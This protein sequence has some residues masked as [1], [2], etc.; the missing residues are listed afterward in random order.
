MAQ[1]LVVAGLRLTGREGDRITDVSFTAPRGS[2]TGLVGPNGGGKSTILKILAGICRPVAG[3]AVFDGNDL[4]V[5]RPPERA[6]SVALLEQDFADDVPM[7]VWDVVDIG[8]TPFRDTWTGDPAGDRIVEESLHRVGC[9]HL[10]Q[11][12]FYDLSGGERQRVRL[13]RC[14]AQQPKLLLLDEPNNHLDIKGQFEMIDILR[15]LVRDGLAVVAVLHDLN[16]A[17]SY[18][19]RLTVIADGHS[20]EEGSCDEVLTPALLEHVYGVAAVLVPHPLIPRPLIAMA[21]APGHPDDGNP[22]Q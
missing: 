21:R 16:L 12:L 5:M 14:L 17:A 19:D 6:R 18:C 8:R 10:E 7:T 9:A 2:L 3:S 20:I 4:L 13:A 22:S 1:G 15:G 11:R